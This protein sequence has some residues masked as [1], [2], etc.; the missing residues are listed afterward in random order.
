[1]GIL[2]ITPD[3]FSDGGQLYSPGGPEADALLARAGQ[4]VADG[5]D[6][7]DVG[8]ESTRPGATSVSTAEELARVVP[9]IE[10]LKAHFPVPVSVDT[11]NP[12]VMRAA[13]DAGA[14]LINDVRSLSRPGAIDAV[15][16]TGLPVCLMHMPAEPDVM[17]NDPHY[18][19][20]VFDVQH[21]LQARAKIC[22]EAGIGRDRIIVDPGFGFGKT[23]DHNLT[24]F[25]GLPQLVELEYPLLVGVSR[26]RMIGDVLERQTADRL[27]GSV[28]L[29]AL[30]AQ[31]G[32]SILRV[33][34]VAETVDALKILNAV[35][36]THS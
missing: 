23:L 13:A 25:R 7:F 2:N 34:D 12:E 15:A 10:L 11:S 8:G 21:F 29:A 32:A 1:M 17:Q 33:H 4:M 24:L 30:A 6:I 3:S 19:D 22:L 31:K 9:A 16:S 35:E 5:V 14:D 26:K 18:D 27:V 36:G 28:T 20:V